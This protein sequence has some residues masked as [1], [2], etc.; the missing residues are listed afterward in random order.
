MT[1]PVSGA[2]AIAWT[3][4]TEA[5][6]GWWQFDRVQAVIEHD[7]AVSIPRKTLLERG[8]ETPPAVKGKVHITLCK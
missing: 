2:R 4:N 1:A 3:R 6:P 8:V 7:P 5:Q